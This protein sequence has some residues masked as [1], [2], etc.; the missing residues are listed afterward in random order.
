MGEKTNHIFHDF[1]TAMWRERCAI[2]QKGNIDTN[3][4][5]YRQRMRE[6]CQQL[7]YIT[8]ESIAR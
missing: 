4:I 6:L 8:M 7:K 1:T 5:R 2:V 3:G